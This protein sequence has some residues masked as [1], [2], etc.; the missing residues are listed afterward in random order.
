MGLRL[1]N[2][3]RHAETAAYSSTR[4]D[5]T[6]YETGTSAKRITDIVIASVALVFVFPLLLVVATLIRLQDGGKAVYAQKRY[7]RNGR[8]FSCYKLRSMVANADERLQEILATDPEARAEW[9]ETQKLVN[10]PRITPLGHFIRK[11]SIDE[12]PQLINI[13]RGEM[14]L[15]GPRPIVENEIAK[16]GEYYRDYCAVRPGLTGLW[17]VEGRS[18]T[19]YE[20]RVQ[21]DVKYAISRTFTG[22]I[23][24]MLRTVP[25]VLLSKGAR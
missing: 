24:I 14:S 21:L 20:E 15:V 18:D 6:E 25:A 8:T 7:G 17:Q 1:S 16:Y 13:I 3:S 9:E 19:T 2:Q 23:M 5:R 22:D 11:T 4:H 12:L 10:D